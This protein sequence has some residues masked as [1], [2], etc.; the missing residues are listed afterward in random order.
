MEFSRQESWERVAISC[1]RGSSPGTRT[2]VSYIDRQILYHCITWEV[3]LLTI[4]PFK[5]YKLGS[6]P[7]AEGLADNHLSWCFLKC[8]EKCPNNIWVVVMMWAIKEYFSD[9]NLATQFYHHSTDTNC[10]WS[11]NWRNIL[12]HILFY[13]CEEQNLTLLTILIFLKLCFLLVYMTLHCFRVTYYPSGVSLVFNLWIHF[14][15]YNVS[16]YCCS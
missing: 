5:T 2:C 15:F 11:L 1:S 13:V 7:V 14:F 3:K 12:I 10:L 8:S 9:K 16:R 4:C 6:V